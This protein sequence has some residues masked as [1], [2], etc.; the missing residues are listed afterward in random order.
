MGTALA[1]QKDY[2]GAMKHLQQAIE[3][4]AQQHEGAIDSNY[5]RKYREVAELK[6]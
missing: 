2:D 3:L 6:K 5:L 1:A 4:D